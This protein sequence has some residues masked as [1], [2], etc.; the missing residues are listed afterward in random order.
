M[1]NIAPV[2]MWISEPRTAGP[3]ENQTLLPAIVS[4]AEHIIASGEPNG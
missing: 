2:I 3:A 4:A 1:P